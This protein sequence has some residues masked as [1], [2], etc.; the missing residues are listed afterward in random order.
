M[1]KIIILA[2]LGSA[3]MYANPTLGGTI[4]QK[5]ND[6]ISEK[7]GMYAG[8]GF[9]TENIGELDDDAT[10]VELSI[11]AVFSSNFGVEFQYS[12]TTTSAES[13][14][15][16]TK[17]TADNKKT[18]LWGTYT[19]TPIEKLSIMGKVG[20]TK[21]KI[22][23][24]GVRSYRYFSYSISGRDS[25]TGL[26]Y[27]LDLKYNINDIIGLYAGYTIFNPEFL[28]DDFDANKLSLGIQV[29]F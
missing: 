22:N 6:V 28:G 12:K 10:G 17:V 20:F 29:H 26:S 1:K 14:V 18:S 25:N 3:V 11:G 9:G 24:Q 21:Y 4:S 23:I 16:Y 27:G 7:I 19:Y 8:I 5:S 13:D 15:G 2:M